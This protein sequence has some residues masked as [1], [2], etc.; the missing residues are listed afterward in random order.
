VALG[1]GKDVLDIATINVAGKTKFDGGR[2]Y[3]WYYISGVNKFGPNSS[4]KGF[5]NLIP[6]G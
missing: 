1:D 2:A 3:D 5:D 4:K 6:D